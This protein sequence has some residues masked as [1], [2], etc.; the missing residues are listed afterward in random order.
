MN[1]AKCKS[2][3]WPQNKYKTKKKWSWKWLWNIASALIQVGLTYIFIW[4]YVSLTGGYFEDVFTLF[5]LFYLSWAF[6]TII[7]I[8]LYSEEHPIF[9][10]FLTI[11]YVPMFIHLYLIAGFE[12]YP[13]PVFSHGAEIAKMMFWFWGII[14]FLSM[15]KKDPK[16]ENNSKLVDDIFDVDTG[17]I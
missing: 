12:I 6:P 11:A 1:R 9:N 17:E 10:L 4:L 3:G 5:T 14:I 7:F 16:K 2:C 8:N 13:N 15:V